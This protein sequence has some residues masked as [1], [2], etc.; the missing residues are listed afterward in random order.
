MIAAVLL[1]AAVSANTGPEIGFRFRGTPGRSPAEG[2][3]VELTIGGEAARA[4]VLVDDGASAPRWNWRDGG[5]VDGGRVTLRAPAESRARLVVRRRP[6]ARYELEGPLRWPAS[7]ASRT[8]RPFPRRTLRGTSSLP[9]GVEIHLVGTASGDALCEIDLVDGWQCAAVP[10]DFTGRLVAC[11]GTYALAAAE[12]PHGSPDEIVMRALFDSALIRV[13]TS[14]PA[15]DSAPA[16]VRLLR[17]ASPGG[18]VLARDPTSEIAELDEGLF[19]LESRA[20]PAGL[21]VEV[22]SRGFATARFAF[23][24]FRTPCEAPESVDLV[25][26]TPLTGTVS[27]GSGG[28]VAGAIVLVRSADPDREPG[29]LA[30]ALTDESGGFEVPDLA[31]RPHRLRA[32]HAEF[33]CGEAVSLPGSEPARI[34]LDG[35]AALIGR[36][37]T[38]AGVPEPSA[39]VRIVP[40]L[41]ASARPGDRLARMPLETTS[42]N[43]GRFRIAFP[44][45]GEF[46]LEIRSESSGVA[47]ISVRC[48]T[49]SPPITDVGD[50]RLPEPL[51]LEVR[52]ALCGAGVVS[53]SGPLGGETSFPAL[54]RFPLDA[55]GA[56]AVR[57]P[58]GGAWT[59]WATCGG[60]NV[61]LAPALLPDVGLLVG[62]EVRFEPVGALGDQSPG[63][64]K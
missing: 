37:L 62:I 16:S 45:T 13:A 30:D 3:A 61:M 22:S 19:W 14:E 27:D 20:D 51:D 43:D 29:V 47:R 8:V 55:E 1:L 40:S 50:V 39:H 6:G 35:G 63:R 23:S 59:A 11:D 7:P 34:A 33:G 28:P 12:V 60:R 56:V 52:V 41:E 18:I 4:D 21:T 54:L 49:L 17:P 26:A 9:S 25:R 36:V 44:D 10:P 15:G 5:S 38:S 24:R 2:I 57:L 48:S 46:L 58:E 64:S 53:M 42:G 32:C 31:P